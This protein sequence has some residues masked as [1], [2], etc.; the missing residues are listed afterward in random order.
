MEVTLNSPQGQSRITT[1]LWRSHPEQTT[2]D[3]EREAL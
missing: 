2:D 3:S 1:K